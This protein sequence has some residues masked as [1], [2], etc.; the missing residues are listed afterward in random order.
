M[1]E[2]ALPPFAKR[3]SLSL[4]WDEA[5]GRA[6]ASLKDEGFG[7]LTEIDVQATLKEK[8]DLDRPRYRI[9]GACNPPLAHKVLEAEPLVGVLLPCNLVL[10]EEGDRIV[11]AAMEPRIIGQ[12][13]DNPVLAE[14]AGKVS[15]MMDRVLKRLEEA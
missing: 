8:L 13:V 3:T 4:P 9:L 1:S 7:V 14:A 12:M 11:V 15:E 6:V 10:W 5:L 2:T